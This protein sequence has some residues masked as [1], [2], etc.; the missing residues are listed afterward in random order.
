MA[1]TALIAALQCAI[2]NYYI[3]RFFYFFILVNLV[4]F[5]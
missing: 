1:P 4:D 2:Y 5:I 3:F